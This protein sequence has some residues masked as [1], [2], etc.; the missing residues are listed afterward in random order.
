MHYDI[1]L[2][3]L[4][5]VSLI[6]LFVIA[7]YDKQ[8]DIICQNK[9]RFLHITEISMKCLSNLQFLIL[10]LTVCKISR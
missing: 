2:P 9:L 3:R 5:R 8:R 1:S 6:F 4:N 10:L 7:Y